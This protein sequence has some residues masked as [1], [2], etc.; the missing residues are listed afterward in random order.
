MDVLLGKRCD[1]TVVGVGLR[2]GHLTHEAREAIRVADVVLSLMAG[3]MQSEL[4]RL[5]ARRAI[6]LND[7]YE[8]GLDRAVT[9]RRM[10][11]RVL[12]EVRQGQSVCLAVYGHPGVFCQPA[13]AAIAEARAEGYSATMLPGISAEDALFADLGID[14]ADR[15]CQSFEAS[16]FL[17]CSKQWDPTSWLVLWQVGVVGEGIYRHEFSSPGLPLLSRRLCEVYGERHEGFLYYL[18]EVATLEPA[19]FPV[20]LS[21]LAEVEFEQLSTLAVPPLGGNQVDAEAVEA[22]NWVRQG[23]R[24][25]TDG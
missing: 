8:D 22:L 12:A 18:P 7:L 15:G 21:A 17:L 13:H 1:L 2:P 4:V 24:R 9:Y 3:P 23:S 20:A 14:P 25:T 5:F 6:S 10:V 19:I 16:Q 11:D